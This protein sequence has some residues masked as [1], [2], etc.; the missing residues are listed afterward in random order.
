VKD[1]PG[2]LPELLLDR[3]DEAGIHKPVQDAVEVME[4]G[5]EIRVSARR[6]DDDGMVRIEVADNGPGISM[7]DVSR[8]LNRTSPERRRAADSALPSWNGSLLITTALFTPNRTSL[9]APGLSSSC[10]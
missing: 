6:A 1:V 10:R 9:K 4:G 2:D 8:L 3:T 5:G 7:E